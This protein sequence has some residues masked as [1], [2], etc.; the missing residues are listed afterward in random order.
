MSIEK[1]LENSSVLLEHFF[2][3]TDNQIFF[4]SGKGNMF[5]FI[6]VRS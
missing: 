6:F 4:F 2:I 1:L 5:F 3:L